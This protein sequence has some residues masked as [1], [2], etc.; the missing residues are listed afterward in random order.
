MEYIGVISTTDPNFL[1]HP[2]V[3]YFQP[4]RP[5]FVGLHIL[6]KTSTEKQI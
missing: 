5:L 3:V 4:K 1:G 2:Y 6:N